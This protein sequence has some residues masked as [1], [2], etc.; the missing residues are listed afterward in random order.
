METIENLKTEGE[1]LGYEGDAFRAFLRI[2]KAGYE[3]RERR[4]LRCKHASVDF[5]KR[6][7]RVN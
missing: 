4:N 6:R 1:A 7:Q 3:T 5:Q 2:S